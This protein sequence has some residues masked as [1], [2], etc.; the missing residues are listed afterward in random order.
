MTGNHD[1]VVNNHTNTLELSKNV[2]HVV[3][4]PMMDLT[5][6]SLC[7]EEVGQTQ[8]QAFC[9]T[10]PVRMEEVLNEVW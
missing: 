1:H 5:F 3:I 7:C 6:F 2:F 8:T 10:D 9:Q 4:S